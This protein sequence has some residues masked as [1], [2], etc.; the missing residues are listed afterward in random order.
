MNRRRW[1]TGAVATAA[2]VYL[3]GQHEFGAGSVGLTALSIARHKV[4]RLIR[5]FNPDRRLNPG[6]ILPTGM[7]CMEVRPMPERLKRKEW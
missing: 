5:V 2:L 7:G 6:K 3:S 4:E 1:L